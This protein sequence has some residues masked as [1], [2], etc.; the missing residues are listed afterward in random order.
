MG[1]AAF[2]LLEYFLSRF[3]VYWHLPFGILL[4]LVVLFLRGGLSGS[5]ARWFDKSDT[6]SE[7]GAQ[8]AVN[9]ASDANGG[10]S[11]VASDSNERKA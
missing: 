4:I 8:T 11:A 1:A 5:L 2:I 10:G 7:S 6:D 3:T 9:S